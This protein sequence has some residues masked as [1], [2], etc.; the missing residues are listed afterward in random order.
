[1]GTSVS[2]AREEPVSDQMVSPGKVRGPGNLPPQAVVVAVT[3]PYWWQQ[4]RVILS[5]VGVGVAAVLAI[6]QYGLLANSARTLSR[7][8]PAWAV[9]AILAES[10]SM[11]A[12]ALVY[13]RL[14]RA[15]DVRIGIGP[16]TAIALASNTIS[17]A[18]PVAGTELGTGYAYRQFRRRG[19]DGPSAAWVL[20]IAGITSSVT[21]WT[22]VAGTAISSRQVASE[23]AGLTVA[24]LLAVA[25]VG[26]IVALHRPVVRARL[27][28]LAVR[29]ATAGLRMIRRP[30]DGV[31]GW[32]GQVAG[33]LGSLRAGRSTVASVALTSTLNWLADIACAGFAVIAVG[34]SVSWSAV[35]LAWAAAGS[36]SSLRLTPGGVGVAEAAMVATLVASGM[37]AGRAT[38]AVLVY[39]L[40][41]YWMLV[42][43]GAA[44]LAAQRLHPLGLLAR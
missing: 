7:A 16:I 1:M 24:V 10:L 23:V 43:A 13:W 29:A 5:A 42:L 19:A 18:M 14:L 4:K 17:G 36:A 34:G 11:L 26:G 30:N 9:L 40:I 12:F 31:E 38:A 3:A 22:L 41:S 35:V 27:Q 8:S 2:V 15:A 20:I 6:T 32:I 44:L 37:P 21:F 33:Q 25:V 39:R 28:R